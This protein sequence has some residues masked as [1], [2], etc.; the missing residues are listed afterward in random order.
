MRRRCRV[1]PCCPGPCWP[2]RNTTVPA[3]PGSASKN[4]TRRVVRHLHPRRPRAENREPVANRW[5]VTSIQPKPSRIANTPRR[6]CIIRPDGRGTASSAT[7]PPRLEEQPA[8]PQIAVGACRP[9]HCARPT[10]K[11][12]VSVPR[13]IIHRGAGNRRGRR[14]VRMLPSGSQ[15][16]PPGPRQR[17][18]WS[19]GWR[20]S[21]ADAHAIFRDV[22]RGLPA[23]RRRWSWSSSGV[24]I[25]PRSAQA[26][27]LAP[28]GA[29][30]PA[31]SSSGMQ[32]GTEPGRASSPPAVSSSAAL[33]AVQVTRR[34]PPSRRRRRAARRAP[35]WPRR[36][37]APVRVSREERQ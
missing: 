13:R 24:G 2:S 29:G 28:G 3:A 30:T 35:G 17:A 25:R 33:V 15:Q 27:S 18:A 31:A 14:T 20:C 6:M 7:E 5:L 26:P 11:P 1:T 21:T 23:A 34:R 8:L 19:S 10:V 22:P 37:A 9:V 36:I 4:A 12:A 16:P 32:K